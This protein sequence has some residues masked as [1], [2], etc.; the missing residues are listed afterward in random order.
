MIPF[1]PSPALRDE[2]SPT[3]IPEATCSLGPSDQSQLRLFIS[4]YLLPSHQE[5]ETSPSRVTCRGTS[6]HPGS[7]SKFTPTSVPQ[8]LYAL[9]EV[10]DGNRA[11]SGVHVP[12]LMGDLGICKERFGRFSENP[13][14]F[15]DG[16]I[17]LG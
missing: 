16:F 12:F 7:V 11:I 2:P 17:R 1:Q 15:R 10:A 5:G 3:C 14:K 13:D 8:G 6:C 4:L 9:R